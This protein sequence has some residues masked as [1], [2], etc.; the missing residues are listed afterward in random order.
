MIKIE[1]REYTIFN[2]SGFKLHENKKP[3]KSG[4]QLNSGYNEIS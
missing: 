4:A 3:R 1:K 2:F